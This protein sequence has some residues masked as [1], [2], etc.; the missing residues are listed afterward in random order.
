MSSALLII[1]ATILLSLVVG[2]AAGRRVTMNLEGWTVGGRQFGLLLVWLLMAGEVYTTFIFLG[3]SGW[4]YARGA[5]AFYI[6]IYGTLA[7]TVSFF[8]LPPLWRV[9]KRHLLHTQPDFFAL[10]YR[11]PA[12]GVLVAVVGGVSIV[13]YLQLQLRGLGLIVEVASGGAIG[14]QVAIAIAFV[15]SCAFV[16]TSGLKGVAWV[17]VLKDVMMITAVAVVGIGVPAIYFGGFAGVLREMAARMPNHLVLPGATDTLGV[18]W[19]M[20]T[21][22]LSGLGFYMWPHLFASTFSAKSDTVIRRNAIIMPFYQLPILLVFLVGFTAAL[23]I[24]GL[25]N[26]DIAL[27]EIVKRTYPPWFL[28]FVG[29]AGAVT[30]MVPAAILVLAAATLLAKNVCVPLLLPRASEATVMSLIRVLVPVVMAAALASALLF[31]NELV[32]LLIL[33]YDGV[34]QLFPGVALG[35]F[36]RRVSRAGVTAGLLVGVAT[37]AALIMSGHDPVLGLNAGFVALVL[38]TLV[39]VAVSLV[40]QPVEGELE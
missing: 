35:L 39:T 15:T 21:T 8:L 29:A 36:W 13:P 30:A 4:A 26:G 17:A 24:P 38:N 6:P 34:S 14:A 31:P 18:A 2:M 5:P 1:L 37:V 16:F 32:N 3:A 19:V 12:L 11:S 33:G 23:V 9:G 40:T 10:R 22:L 28:G 25:A 27:L 20:S 7:Y